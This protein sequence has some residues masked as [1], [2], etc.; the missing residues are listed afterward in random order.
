MHPTV[1]E[2]MDEDF[3]ALTPSRIRFLNEWVF[4]DYPES[5]SNSQKAA[6]MMCLEKRICIMEQIDL[7]LD[8]TTEELDELLDQ[9]D[10][11]YK[12]ITTSQ[13]SWETVKYFIS[14]SEEHLEETVPE[15]PFE[16]RDHRAIGQILGYPEE[17]IDYFVEVG[18]RSETKEFA[19]DYYELSEEEAI[20]KI[21]NITHYIGYLPAPSERSWENALSRVEGLPNLYEKFVREFI[22]PEVPS[23]Q[24]DQAEEDLKDLNTS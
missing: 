9:T 6:V 1:R 13:G 10:L 20:D 12:K 23:D 15:N 11:Y 5:S 17:A 19:M 2:G 4:E 24:L 16:P 21:H 8:N 22:L 7:I 18:E 3:E 14:W